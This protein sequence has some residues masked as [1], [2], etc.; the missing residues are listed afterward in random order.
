MP[1]KNNKS[2]PVRLPWKILLGNSKM[3]RFPPTNSWIPVKTGEIR[4]PRQPPDKQ[5]APGQQTKAASWLSL[6]NICV[7]GVVAA[8]L[9][10]ATFAIWKKGGR[11][12]LGL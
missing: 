11:A 7:V 2:E 10:I 8:I 4:P 6:K 5:A 3:F 12:Y 1:P 9:G